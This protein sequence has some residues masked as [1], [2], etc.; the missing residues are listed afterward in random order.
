MDFAYLLHEPDGT[1]TVEGDRHVC[2]L[3]DRATW[4]GALEDAGF[5][6]AIETVELSDTP[7][8]DVFLGRRPPSG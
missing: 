7:A 8:M 2:G 4:L 5:G 1:I 3:F 6:G